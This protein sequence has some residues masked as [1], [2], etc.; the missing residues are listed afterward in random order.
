MSDRDELLNLL[1]QILAQVEFLEAENRD[2]REAAGVRARPN[3]R[4]RDI[5][6]WIRLACEDEGMPWG[7]IIG[8]CKLAHVVRVRHAAMVALRQCGWSLGDVGYVFHRDHTTIIH[9]GPRADQKL[10]AK[11]LKYRE[12]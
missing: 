5:P 1:T 7:V 10:V 12:D 11:M 2:L 4:R 9:A 8:T 3:S 6:T